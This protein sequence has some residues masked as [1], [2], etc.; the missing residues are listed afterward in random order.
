[1]SREKTFPE[2][3]GRVDL[4]IQPVAHLFLICM[5][6]WVHLSVESWFGLRFPRDSAVKF[7]S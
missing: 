5:D 7:T 1:M 4:V 3:E 6:P 2:T